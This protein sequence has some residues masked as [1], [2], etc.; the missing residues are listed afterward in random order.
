MTRLDT[1]ASKHRHAGLACGRGQDLLDRIRQH[2]T[3]PRRD[4]KTRHV[5]E[6][7]L[8]DSSLLL[9]RRRVSHD[10]RHMLIEQPG[11]LGSPGTQ[12]RLDTSAGHGNLTQ[13]AQHGRPRQLVSAVV[14]VTRDRVD[15]GRGQQPGVGVEPQRAGGQTTA[16]G[17][18]PDRHQLR[19]WHLAIVELQ[20]NRR[21]APAAGACC[22]ARR[23]ARKGRCVARQ[24]ARGVGPFFKGNGCSRST[25]CQHPYTGAIGIS[26]AR[27]CHVL[28][29]RVCVVVAV[30]DSACSVRLVRGLFKPAG[31]S[32]V[33]PPAEG[34]S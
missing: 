9:C 7:G 3:L 4:R 26:G 27:L 24:L 13:L 28:V 29:S 5:A 20:P 25:R 8:D 21:S 14:A 18:D 19:I 22:P 34:C 16:L 33:R 11:H 6:R 10:L 32:S 2:G 15:F 23:P 30:G 1:Q 17:K 12:Y 31:P